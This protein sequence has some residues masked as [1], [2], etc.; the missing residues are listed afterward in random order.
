VND[1][2]EFLGFARRL[3]FPESVEKE[4]LDD[5]F[6]NSIGSCRAS[7]LT[8]FGLYAVFGILDFWGM[9]SRT[10]YV[11][12]IRYL[13]VCPIIAAVLLLSFHP[14]FKKIMQPATMFVVLVAGLGIVAMIAAT[15]P[16]DPAYTH[17][18]AGLILVVVFGF[19]FVRLRLRF[20]ILSALIIVAAYELVTILCQKIL[21]ETDGLPLFL[22]SNFFLIGA[23][24]LGIAS[25]YFLEFYMRRDFVQR[26]V[27]ESEL[28]SAREIQQSLLPKNLPEIEGI[29]IAA[30]C[31]TS[32]YVGGDHYD[33][34]PAGKGEWIFVV[35]DVSGKGA[36]AALLMANFHAMMRTFP[37][38]QE[39]LDTAALV[40]EHVH[41]LMH[42]K[43]YVTAILAKYEASSRI[44][45]S[46][47]AGHSGGLV[48]HPD[49][50][51]VRIDSTGFPLGMFHDATWELQ[52]MEM[53]P[54]TTLLLYTDGIVDRENSAGES[55]DERR[56]FELVT[57]HADL[58]ASQVLQ[59]IFADNDEFAG[60]LPLAD[61]S[62]I[63]L[64]RM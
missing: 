55:Y 23:S 58:P 63:L 46:L 44:L 4:F 52:R 27:I 25:G 53:P 13:L 12:T 43:R 24:I 15:E 19:T 26:R 42:Q 9:P 62:T 22:N 64:A 30:D 5:Y 56:L 59:I 38:G 21:N 50:R 10:H 6:R 28:V 34:L 60:T 11:W 3:R 1:N 32:R 2:L 29:S 14:I 41:G 57:Q 39:L 31:R 16:K 54:G 33:V 40:N 49:G 36:A 45:T 48:L 20:G 61:D 35:A 47:N 17:Y 51:I 8:A 37:P 18:Y 7:L